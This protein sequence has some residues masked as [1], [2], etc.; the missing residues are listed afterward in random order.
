M[1]DLDLICPI[2][3]CR[4]PVNVTGNVYCEV[5]EFDLARDKYAAEGDATVY[6][7][8]EGHSFAYDPPRLIE[9]EAVS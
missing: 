9:N 3:T 4:K 6:S 1:A 2:R 7:C 5:G 8:S